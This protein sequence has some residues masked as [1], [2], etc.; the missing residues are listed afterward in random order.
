MFF[1]LDFSLVAVMECLLDLLSNLLALLSKGF[2]EKDFGI[3][4]M[5]SILVYLCTTDS[6][7]VSTNKMVQ[8]AGK[9]SKDTANLEGMQRLKIGYARVSKREQAED[10]N[11]LKQQIERLKVA[12]AEIIYSDVQKG[13]RDD[14]PQFQAVLQLI[15][16]NKVE[17]LYIVRSERITRSLPMLIKI[18]EIC[19][20][21][22]TAFVMI[23]QRFDSTT[24]QGKLML[25]IFGT[26]SEWE[27]DQL[28]ERVRNGKEYQRNHH[29]PY[30][31]CP[32]GYKVEHYKYVLDQAP[33]LCLLSDRPDNYLDYTCT[34]EDW[35]KI[36]P[37]ED[38]KAMPGRS[39]AQVARDCVDFFFTYPGLSIAL[40]A[41]FEKYGVVHTSANSNGASKVL[42]WTKR[43]FSL[44]LQ[45]PVLEGHIAYNKTYRTEDDK[46]RERPREEW[47]F[48]YNTHADQRLMTP[49][50]AKEIREILAN[51][52]EMQGSAFGNGK[53]QAYGNYSY[54]TG[55]IYCAECGCRAVNKTIGSSK[56]KTTYEYFACRH[57]GQ[58]C[59]KVPSLKKSDIEDALIAALVKKAE[60][61]SNGQTSTGTAFKSKL[62]KNLEVQLEYLEKFPGFNPEAEELKQ[63]LK[64][65]I[66]AETNFFKSER[67]E[68]KTVEE[69]ILAGQSQQVWRSLSVNE[70]TLVFRRIVHKIFIRGGK[71]ESI[72]F[73]SGHI[74]HVLPPSQH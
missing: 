59:S 24:P 71:V 52:S 15:K 64:Y 41:I 48:V 27:V 20:R 67:F 68:N 34:D 17:V 63:R 65:Q 19:K 62:L 36:L 26:L 9:L 25:N 7:G 58:G 69:I 21:H 37:I 61:L 33:H 56:S 60:E 16:E 2:A 54:Q 46:K 72:V 49:D 14:R 45:N 22:N 28:S 43:G 47:K 55:L 6:G 31:L 51:N 50:E 12:G 11:A 10:T 1:S 29:R 8:L 57:S 39:V 73:N 32:F 13:K 44:W 35:G 18:T 3:F 70:K 53:R 4:Q 66:E 5:L 38:L 40:K 23:D 74:S 30:G 42:H